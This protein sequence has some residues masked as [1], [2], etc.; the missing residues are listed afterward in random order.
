MTVDDL[1]RL[2]EGLKSQGAA[3]FAL[4]GDGGLAVSFVLADAT[5]QAVE[6]LLSDEDDDDLLFMSGLSKRPQK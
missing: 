4:T 2:S 3:S 6:G 1:L 5:A